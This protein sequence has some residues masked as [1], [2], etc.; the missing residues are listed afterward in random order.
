ML[1]VIKELACIRVSIYLLISSVLCQKKSCVV[2]LVCL[3]LSFFFQLQ[4]RLFRMEINISSLWAFCYYVLNTVF[5]EP[6]AK[7]PLYQLWHVPLK[8]TN[9]YKL[10]YSLTIHNFEIQIRCFLCLSSVFFFYKVGIYFQQESS[11]QCWFSNWRHILFIK[12]ISQ[13]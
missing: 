3:D 2:K 13:Q 12:Y 7:T 4:T 6:W 1:I 8:W 5:Q 10:Y 11:F 9:I